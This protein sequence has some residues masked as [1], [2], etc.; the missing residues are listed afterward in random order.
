MNDLAVTVF[1]L[2]LAAG[3]VGV[4]LRRRRG[5]Q[6]AISGIVLATVLVVA[7]ALVATTR[8]GTTLSLDV[9]GFPAGLAIVLGVDLLSALM[10]TVG[11]LM[12]LVGVVFA[13][14]SGEDEHPLFHPLVMFLWTGVAL[15]FVTADLFNL[16]VAFEV[17]LIASYVLLTLR[18]GKDQVRAGVIYVGTNLL[19]ST[20]F[21]LGVG[22]IYG[23]TGSVNLAVVAAA[24]PDARG[25]V[26]GLTVLLIAVAAKAGLVP[27]HGWLPRTY[28]HASPA[29]TAIFSALLTKAGVYVLYRLTST[30][31]AGIDRY[32]TVMLVI[33]TVTMVVGVLGAVGGHD[34]RGILTF[35]MV[36]QVGYLV[37]PLGIWTR[38][39]IAAGILYLLQYVAV[40]GALFLVAASVTRLEGT[41]ELDELGGLMRTRPWLGV[42]FL[43]PALALAGLPP[44]SGFVGKFLLVRAA[45]EAGVY[46][47]G[48]VAVGV[49][50][51]TL[52]S[53]VKIFNGAFWGTRSE[54][55]VASP[56]PRP[57]GRG[58]ARTMVGLPLAIG[59]ATLVL[60]VSASGLLELATAAADALVDPSAY[61][62]AVTR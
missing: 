27:L 1:A 16:F 2:P 38:A 23:A 28:V 17:M 40:K 24:I 10:L 55:E 43:L 5:V 4:L 47:A 59:I 15:A 62:S 20:L 11:S 52:L 35:H 7:V 58:S 25:A 32:L 6:R 9:G 30:M 49:S 42:A 22:M 19:A 33:A 39:T 14:A 60:G 48:A 56:A 45:F 44:T 26:A 57:P 21:L 8:D 34:M 29:V 51:L 3:A 13:V 53:M 36:S 41:D 54:P 46:W 18:G 31:L 12:T 37:L 61:L 50:L